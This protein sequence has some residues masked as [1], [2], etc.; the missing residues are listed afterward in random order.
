MSGKPEDK[1][2]I[3]FYQSQA[4][5]TRHTNL[6]V[7]KSGFKCLLPLLSPILSLSP[8]PTPIWWDFSKLEK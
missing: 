4:F 7:T 5:L 8:T 1:N 6:G 2:T 3:F